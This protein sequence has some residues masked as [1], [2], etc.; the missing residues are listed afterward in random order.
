MFVTFEGPEGAGKSTALA[1]AAERLRSEGL[2]VVI[3]R[4]P[5][6]GEVGRHIREI[7]LHGGD[8][9]H[10]AELLLFLADR[11]QHVSTLIKPALAQGKWVF[12]DRHADSTTVYQALVRGLDEDFVRRGNAFATNGLKPNLTLL[13]DIDP[14]VGLARQESKDRL[15]SMPLEFHQ[16][17]RAGFLSEAK[18]EPRRWRTIDAS[19]PPERV[20]E[21]ILLHLADLQNG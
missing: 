4:E 3:T 19:K 5:G 8:L 15:D 16:R 18:K 2:D 13:L 10:R 1:A 7:L 9:E 11:A 12:C 20:L 14:V 6:A 21:E 17:V